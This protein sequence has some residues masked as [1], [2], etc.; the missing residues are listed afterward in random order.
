MEHYLLA[1]KFKGSKDLYTKFSLDVDS[2]IGKDLSAAKRFAKENRASVD[3]KYDKKAAT[4]AALHAKFTQNEDL[5]KLLLATN[6]A[7]LSYFV[8]ESEPVA[9]EELMSVRDQ[10]RP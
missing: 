7:K 2:E 6:K 9:Y 5:K 10:L 3:P 1:S 4:I 8:K